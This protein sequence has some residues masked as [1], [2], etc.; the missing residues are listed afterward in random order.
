MDARN[1]LEPGLDVVQDYKFD[2]VSSSDKLMGQSA[3]VI[4]DVP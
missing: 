3:N 4:S 1:I 2:F